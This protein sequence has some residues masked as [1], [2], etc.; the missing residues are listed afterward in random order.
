MHNGIAVLDFGGQYAHLIA[1]RIRRLQVWSEVFPPDVDASAV[2]GFSGLILSGG[3]ASVYDPDQPAFNKA[4]LSSGLPVLGLCY[5]HQLVCQ[6]L[7]GEVARGDVREY[8]S[9]KLRIQSANGLFAGME[10]PLVVWMSHGDVASRLPAGF[11]VLGT[12]DDCATAAVGDV[13]RNLY[14][15]QFHPEVA[16]TARGMDI[17]D[18]FL[19]I[20]AA[21][22]TWTMV[23]YAETAMEEIREQVGEKRVFLLVSGGVDSSVAFAL[24]NRAL[25]PERVLGLHI[26]NGFMRKCESDRVADAL[27]DEGFENLIVEDASEDFLLSVEGMVEP[28]QKRLAIGRAFLEIKDRVLDRMGLDSDGWLLGQGTLYP[29]TIESGG[30][31]HAAVIKTHHNRVD[32]VEELIAR[33]LVI[34]PLAQLYKD[35]VR[36]L[37]NA[38]GLPPHLIWRQPFPGPGLS[39][40]CL[41]SPG[42][43]ASPP[44]G[45]AEEAARDI[46]A[47][48][49]LGLRVLPLQ[50]VGVQGDFRTYAHPAVVWGETDWTVLEDVST[51]ITNTIS[52]INRV[53]YLLAPTALPALKLKR[54]FL[55]QS[56]LDLLRDVDA[57]AM[58]A[59]EREGLSKTVSQM[60]TVL[61]P[62]TSDGITETVVLR[63]VETPDF[64][65]ARFSALPFDFVRKLA[66]DILNEDGIEAVLYDVTHKPPGTV[67]WE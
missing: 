14:G 25:G 62:L 3:P 64:M 13:R 35:E 59:L 65:T 57:L 21:P 39:V 63:P 11:E 32:V 55:T 51:R 50:S 43:G 33:G 54:A 37:G 49:G 56:R 26:N 22:R 44:D 9:A 12:T 16:H 19:N 46:A 45:K 42:A 61:L 1:N 41:C 40:R 20:C 29:D 5:G 52:W 31:E 34:E 60:P 7:G 38:L 24:F 23:G 15:L 2:D 6:E 4:H 47:G 10:S 8:G 30:T 17:L 66:R 67:E 18:N 27:R 36:E 28:E 58:A 53:V 48:A